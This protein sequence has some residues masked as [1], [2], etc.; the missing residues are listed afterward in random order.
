MIDNDIKHK[1]L[2]CEPYGKKILHVQKLVKTKWSLIVFLTLITGG[3]WLL[4]VMYNALIRK[5]WKC[6]ECGYKR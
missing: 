3:L 6:T 1:Y 4:V 5:R 2:I